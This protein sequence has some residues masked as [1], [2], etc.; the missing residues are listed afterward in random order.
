[1]ADAGVGLGVSRGKEA[2]GKFVD[3]GDVLYLGLED[4]ER[5]MHS[6]VTKI[7]GDEIKEWPENF[8]FRWRLDALDEGGLDYIEEWLA[9]H[10]NPRLVVIDVL[11][12]V[13]GRKARDEEQYQYDYRMLSGL[14]GLATR[15]RVAIVV[16]HH[17]RKSDANDVLDTVSGTTGIAGAADNV[18]VLGVTP[19]GRGST[20]GGATTRSRTRSSSSTTRPPSG[21][22]SATRRDRSRWRAP[23]DFEEGFRSAGSGYLAS[24]A[25]ADHREAERD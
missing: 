25:G 23:G 16:V 12:K 17:V 24:D 9:D 11:A 3:K 7:L 18:M 14:Q 4:G 8:T 5:R 22:S 21:R 1:M 10:P 2:L 20:S 19:T 13:R 15:Y 6:R